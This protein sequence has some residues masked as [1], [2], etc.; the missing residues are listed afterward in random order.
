MSYYNKKL[1]EEI[2]RLKLETIALRRVRKEME[3]QIEEAD[4]I[5]QH[6]DA[7]I[8]SVAESRNWRN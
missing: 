1:K 3:S 7:H 5:E 4:Y 2:R 8:E 6:V